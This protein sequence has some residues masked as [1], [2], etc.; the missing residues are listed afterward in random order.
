[1]TPPK[2]CV[3]LVLALITTGCANQVEHHPLTEAE[4]QATDFHALIP[5]RWWGDEAPPD[6]A[7]EVSRLVARSEISV[8]DDRQDFNMLLI[9]GG[10]ANGAF[11]AGALVGWSESG[12]RPEFQGVT[13]V[14]TGA[15]IAPFAFLGPEYDDQLVEAYSTVDRKSIYHSTGLRGLLFGSS[16]ADTKP[17]RKL[18]ESYI[19]PEVVAAIAREYSKGRRLAIVTTH[20]DALRPV[21]WQ[22]GAIAHNR[23][24][25]AVPLIRQVI[26]ASAA[27]PGFFPPVALT[28]EKDGKEFTELHVDGA[29][30]RQ[31][32]AYPAQLRVAQINEQLG[33]TLRMRIFVIQNSN[34]T[35][36]YEPASTATSAIMRRALSGLLQNQLTGD[37]ER[38]YYL[39]LRDGVDFNML[40]IP[41]D[42]RA[43]RPN[44][45]DKN[46]MRALLEE[47]RS[48]GRT[49]SFWKK[50]PPSEQ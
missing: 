45:F 23:G 5:E 4:Y 10:S 34:I 48:I 24:A 8:G 29:V 11:G 17:L 30:S 19:T 26:L 13:G 33:N 28:W 38:T 21:I 25:A 31:V 49:G 36:T 41:D 15:L 12:Q 18:V 32:F 39:A 1:M 14:S 35:N 2:W 42:F 50:K 37:V 46:Y 43:D 6:V 47:G 22:I 3:F 16:I 7:A 9:S 40:A 44:D 27:I 20:L